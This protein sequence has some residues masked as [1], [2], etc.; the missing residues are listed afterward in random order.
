MLV[1]GAAELS[2]RHRDAVGRA[3]LLADQ[4]RRP[5]PVAARDRRGADCAPDLEMHGERV[6]DTF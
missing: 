3:V 5:R 2:V 4:L 1:T 6:K